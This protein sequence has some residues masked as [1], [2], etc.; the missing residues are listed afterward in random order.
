MK[1]Y[2]FFVIILSYSNPRESC[3]TP[4]GLHL[5]RI[6]KTDGDPLHLSLWYAK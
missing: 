1:I 6:T 4:M 5:P 2:R 3:G